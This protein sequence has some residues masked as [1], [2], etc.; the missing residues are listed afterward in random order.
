MNQKAC[1]ELGV[2]I[3]D[4]YASYEY[5]FD[6]NGE[7]DSNLTFL[8]TC[9]FYGK[10]ELIHVALRKHGLGADDWIFIGDGINDVSVANIAPPCRLVLHRLMS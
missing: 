8:N 9:N 6:R 10:H 1:F 7:I 2:D 5:Y 4:S 3:D